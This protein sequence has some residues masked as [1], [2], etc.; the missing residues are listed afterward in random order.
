[1]KAMLNC[2]EVPI[3]RTM[4]EKEAEEYVMREDVIKV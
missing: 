1:M 3:Y 4:F 2:K